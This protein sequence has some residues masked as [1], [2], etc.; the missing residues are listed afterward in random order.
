MALDPKKW[1]TKTQEAVAAAGDGV[2]AAAPPAADATLMMRPPLP[3]AIIA[4]AARRA[5]GS[6]RHDSK[7]QLNR[8]DVKKHSRWPL[9]LLN[10]PSSA[11]TNA[12]QR[13]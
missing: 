8:T 4:C 7:K 6:M 12:D 10:Q 11:D 13:V 1:T 3:A 9:S 5:P 2:R